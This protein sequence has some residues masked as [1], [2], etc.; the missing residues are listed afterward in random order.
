LDKL[1][2]Q[3]VARK[4]RG[5]QGTTVHTLDLGILLLTW[6]AHDVVAS[7]TGNAFEFRRFFGLG[8]THGALEH[9][10]NNTWV[11]HARSGM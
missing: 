10:S 9:H 11:G 4:G 6:T 3:S 1:G 5:K 8:A 2:P 7:G